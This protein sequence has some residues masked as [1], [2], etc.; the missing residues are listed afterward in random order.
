MGIFIP[1]DKL[2]NLKLYKYSSVDHS[3]I[4]KYVLKSWWNNFVK[5]FPLSM[6]P[7]AITLL[8]L[9]WIVVDLFIVFYYDPYL[10]QPSPRWVYFFYALCLFMY[11]T[12]D[13]CDGCHARRT[14]QSGPL[15]ELFDHSIDAINTTFGAII[16]SSVLQ[17]GWGNLMTLAQFAATANFY[18]STWEEYHTHTLYL[19]EFSGP[20][21]GILMIC[22]V[23]VLT[24]IFGPEIWHTPL[25]E[26][27]LSSIGG[28]QHYGVD[29]QS[30]YVVLGLGSLY[31][32]IQSAI[33]NVGKYYKGLNKA[34]PREAEI[35]TSQ[36]LRGWYPFVGYWVSVV[37]LYWSFPEFQ[38]DYGFPAVFS[39]GLTIAFAVGRIILAHLTLQ[40]FPFRNFP[41][42]VPLAQYVITQI[43]LRFYGFER[44]TVFFAVSWLGLGVTFGIHGSF[45]ADIIYEITTYLDIYT[46]SIKHKRA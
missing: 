2:E 33:K 3:I 24:G 23:Y 9:M 45:V 8:G 42:V 13:G 17:F 44:D 14:G 27:D 19:S 25:F 35:R 15:G 6:A 4:T 43:C 41:M 31:F 18:A 32:N 26:L 11:Q 28:S 16:F 29:F 5:I 20:V 37:F 40:S 38:R 21:E 12:F 36:A 30:F 39:V 46:L 1:K 34:N 10:D 7:N 22:A